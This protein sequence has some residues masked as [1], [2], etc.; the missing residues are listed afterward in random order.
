MLKSIDLLCRV[1]SHRARSLQALE[2]QHGLPAL[3]QAL[4]SFEAST[5]LRLALASL[6]SQVKSA[7]WTP[8]EPPPGES[9]FLTLQSTVDRFHLSADLEN[10]VWADPVYRVLIEGELGLEE[11]L[12]NPEKELEILAQI[13]GTTA[14][15][16]PKILPARPLP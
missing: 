2:R 14:Q 16:L 8:I 7:P 9:P 11:C 12:E 3:L 1:L 15:A 4:E 6:A 5:P 10:Y 13:L